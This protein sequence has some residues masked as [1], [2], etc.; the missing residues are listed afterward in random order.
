LRIRGEHTHL[1]VIQPGQFCRVAM[2][3]LILQFIVCLLP[4]SLIKPYSLNLCPSNMLCTSN[5]LSSHFRPVDAVVEIFVNQAADGDI[6]PSD[7]IKT[8]TDL[9]AWFGVILGSNNSFDS[10]VQDDVGELIAGKEG[11][12]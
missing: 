8:V 5:H 6:V 2:S 4:S 3:Y 12:N 10:F 9:R 11:A 1:V 7:Q